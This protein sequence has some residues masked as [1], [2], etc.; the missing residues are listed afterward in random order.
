MACVG[1]INPARGG[2]SLQFPVSAG[3]MLVPDTV[4]TT[5]EVFNGIYFMAHGG[6][7]SYWVGG[8]NVLVLPCISSYTRVQNLKTKFWTNTI[9]HDI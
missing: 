6:P 8:H 2:S 7:T 3:Q 9:P 1:K 4:R 5:A